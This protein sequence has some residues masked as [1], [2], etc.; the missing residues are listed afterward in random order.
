MGVIGSDRENM[1]PLFGAMSSLHG[2]SDDPGWIMSDDVII[3]G[4]RYRLFR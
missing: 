3:G 4:I 1:V 2:R